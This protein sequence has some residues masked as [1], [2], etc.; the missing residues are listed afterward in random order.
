MQIVK[1]AIGAVFA[2]VGIS[3]IVHVY[4]AGDRKQFLGENVVSWSRSNSRNVAQNLIFSKPVPVEQFEPL[5]KAIEECNV[6]LVQKLI[7]MCPDL[8]RIDSSGNTPLINAIAHRCGKIVAIL[9]AHNADPN[10]ANSFTDRHPLAVAV[11][12]GYTEIVH[13][14]LAAHANPN[15]VSRFPFNPPLLLVALKTNRAEVFN[16]LLQGGADFEK[17][18]KSGDLLD[19][20]IDEKAPDIFFLLLNKGIFPNDANVDKLFTKALAKGMSPVVEV[21]KKY[22]PDTVEPSVKNCFLTFELNDFNKVI[23]LNVLAALTYKAPVIISRHI[24]DAM[25]VENPLVAGYITSGQWSLFVSATGGL[26][27][28]IPKK[29]GDSSKLQEQYGYINM[30]G[31]ILSLDSLPPYKRFE[32]KAV[33]NFS[34]W[35]S[36]VKQL[37]EDFLNIID[38]SSQNHSTRFLLNGH[39]VDG[40]VA[41]IPVVDIHVF[42]DILS[43]IKAE[44]LYVSTCNAAGKNLVKIQNIIQNGLKKIIV[45]FPIIIEASTD[46]SITINFGSGSLFKKLDKVFDATKKSLKDEQKNI[47]IFARDVASTAIN[48]EESMPSLRLPGTAAFFRAIDLDKMK[49]ITWQGIQTLRLAALMDVVQ[50]NK[51]FK[52][53]SLASS[54]SVPMNAELLKEEPGVFT[55][56][57]TTMVDEK[58][59]QEKNVIAKKLIAAKE[60]VG[61]LVLDIGDEVRYVQMFPCNLTDCTINIKGTVLPKF[62]SKIPGRSYHFIGKICYTST[63][64]TCAEALQEFVDNCFIKVFKTATLTSKNWFIK[65]VEL[66]LAGGVRESIKDL[67]VVSNGVGGKFFHLA[68]Q[69]REQQ[70]FLRHIQGKIFTD[71]EALFALNVLTE[72]FPDSWSSDKK[73]SQALTKKMQQDIDGLN[74]ALYESTAGQEGFA[75]IRE[76]LVGFLKS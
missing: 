55:S 31:P 42:F 33:D 2:I 5:M 4:G 64:N 19:M 52:A 26:C 68:T 18:K 60:R 1:C 75:T 36:I 20:A 71:I 34:L 6:D 66:T 9:L 3:L 16:M 40:V 35:R 29:I 48:F 67:V 28:I 45:N 76:A 57:K 21:L 13:M 61:S 41:A 47:E 22:L 44:F 11:K 59:E 7:P 23:T 15:Y 24:L 50:L 56:K 53:L 38:I 62:I 12:E 54:L 63:K 37:L 43:K 46:V 39:G 10:K 73:V 25:T 32:G 30:R 72:A 51:E 69:T 17:F 49:I 8:D 27:L 65:F 14:L 70:E 74:A 58:F